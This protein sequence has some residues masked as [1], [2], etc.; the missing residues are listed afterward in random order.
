MF[1]FA[2]YD[3]R[4]EE[5]GPP[6]RVRH[7]AAV[8][9]RARDGGVTF[10]SELKGLRP[11]VGTPEI[12]AS[13]VVASLLYSWIP[14]SRCVWRGVRKLEAGIWLQVDSP[15]QPAADV[16]GDPQKELL[17]GRGTSTHGGGAADRAGRLRRSPHG[18]GRAGRRVPI[19]RVGLESPLGA[20]RPAHQQHPRLHRLL[21]TA[22]TSASRPCR[23][24]SSTR[25]GW[26]LDHGMM[27]H[28]VQVAPD[29]S[30]L[31]PGHGANPRRAHRGC[32]GG[33][34]LPDLRLLLGRPG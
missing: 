30:D 26:Q 25:A 24:T 1:A 19:G 9:R 32:R 13:A 20:G 17:S 29:V 5:G 7:Q 2:L 4:T 10:A 8:L 31:L 21:P 22:R 6:R 12:D 15:G 34:R 14:D 27:L 3:E 28:E 11:I 23:T 33:Q 16:V 18:R